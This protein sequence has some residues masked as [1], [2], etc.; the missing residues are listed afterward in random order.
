M[1]CR[2]NKVFYWPEAA[3]SDL[4]KLSKM[5]FEQLPDWFK[6]LHSITDENSMIL[7]Y[8][9][10][11][12]ITCSEDM[13]VSLQEAKDGTVPVTVTSTLGCRDIR[14]LAFVIQS[15]MINY[16]IQGTVIIGTVVSSVDNPAN[17]VECVLLVSRENA[18][19]GSA[20]AVLNSMDV[21]GKAPAEAEP[22]K[23]DAES[24]PVKADAESESAAE[25]DAEDGSVEADAESEPAAEA[26][27]APAEEK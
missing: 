8:Y 15:V 14:S 6:Q 19:F 23:A 10:A 4:E 2:Y 13:V 27:A 25:A 11:G 3:A 7:A 5:N 24:E 1:I 16:E 18:V 17:L 22:A 9:K 12:A 26:E 21:Y 20:L